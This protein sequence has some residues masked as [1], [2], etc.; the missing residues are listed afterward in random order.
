MA[1]TLEYTNSLSLLACSYSRE[2][3]SS[4]S[5]PGKLYNLC[6]VPQSLDQPLFPFSVFLCPMIYSY[7]PYWSINSSG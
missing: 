2:V 1:C 4:I 3:K 6:S 7:R 5:H